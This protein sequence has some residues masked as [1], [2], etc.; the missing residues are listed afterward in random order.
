MTKKLGLFGIASSND[1]QMSIW[2]HLMLAG[3]YLIITALVVTHWTDLIPYSLFE[4][5]SLQG[6]VMDWIVVA[7]PIFAWGV[8]VNLLIGWKLPH[9]MKPLEAEARLTIGF[10]ISVFAGVVEEM[11]FRWVYFLFFMLT[12]QLGDFILGGFIFNHGLVWLIFNYILEPLANLT[13]LYQLNGF[14][15]HPAGWFVGA[16]LLSANAHFRDGHKYQGLPGL[17]NSWFIG[18]Y[19]FYIA[20]T[21][22][23][24]AAILVH[25]LYDFL[26][27][28]TGYIKI[29]VLS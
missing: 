4:M 12:V 13:T 11:V 8:G 28:L 18:M 1:K 19:L 7:W 10:I 23:L 3:I 24:P 22:G 21:Y 14:L 25:F 29:K 15:N 16:G 9:R 17:I 26:I 27:F 20:L 2:L 6:E 5:W